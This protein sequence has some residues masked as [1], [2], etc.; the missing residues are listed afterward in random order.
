[1]IV[2]RRYDIVVSYLEGPTTHILSGCP[3]KDTKKVAWVHTGIEN[4]KQIYV[5]FTSGEAAIR[6]YEAFDRIVFV[7]QTAK[8]RFEDATGHT[9][10]SECVHYNVVDAKVIL[11]SA[12][13]PADDVS[14]FETEFNI[15]S[16]GKLV[17]LK[18]YDRLAEIHNRLIR[19]GY[20]CHTY[21]LGTGPEK[22]NL[23]AYLAKEGLNDSFTLVGFRDN[24]YKYVSKADLFVCSSRREG[25]ST[26]VSEALVLGIPVVST[27]CSGARELLGDNEYGLVTENDEEALYQG[28]KRLLDDPALLAHYREKA[29]I[30]GKAFDPEKTV[31]AVEKM[32]LGL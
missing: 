20:R 25:F 11:S 7:S 9:F 19:E 14:F 12:K 8:Q 16:T 26:A 29:R 23:E 5:G 17:S 3:Y 10:S 22:K 24:P 27:D 32:L 30:R 6:G 2:G 28:I 4:A 13:E 15:V 18:G 21:I 1:M 31:I